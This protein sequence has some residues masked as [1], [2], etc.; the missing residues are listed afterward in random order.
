MRPEVFSPTKDEGWKDGRGGSTSPWSPLRLSLQAASPLLLVS[1][2]KSCLRLLLLSEKARVDELH[3]VGVGDAVGGELLER[4]RDAAVPLQ[5]CFL[6]AAA[7]ARI[8]DLVLSVLQ[9]RP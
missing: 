6:D 2:D 3:E 8:R 4:L 1:Y 5:Q 9:P 7:Q